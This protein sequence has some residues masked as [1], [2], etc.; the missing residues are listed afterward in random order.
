[1]YQ[2]LLYQVYKEDQDQISGAT[3]ISD[4]VF[5]HPGDPSPLEIAKRGGH[6]E[7]VKLLEAAG[8]MLK[9]IFGQSPI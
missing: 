9:H 7:V 6:N 2:V 4:V 5:C 3:Y 1:M 8:L